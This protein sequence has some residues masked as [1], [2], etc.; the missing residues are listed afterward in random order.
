MHLLTV[1]TMSYTQ[2][3]NSIKPFIN[4]INIEF[5]A[6]YHFTT[7]FYTVLIYS[8]WNSDTIL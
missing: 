4:I 1:Q 7:I 6:F 8:G 5:F 2:K 3:L